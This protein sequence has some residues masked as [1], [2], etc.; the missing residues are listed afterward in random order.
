MRTVSLMVLAAMTYASAKAVSPGE[1]KGF[2]V[3][4]PAK[5]PLEFNWIPELKCWVGRHEVTQAQY[6]AV[7]GTNPSQF[8]ALSNPVDSVSWH[9]ATGFCAKLTSSLH[10]DRTLSADLEIRLPWEKEWTVFVGDAKL[11]DAVHQRWDARKG[12]L[13]P[14]PVGSLAA[15]NYALY[16]VRGNVFEWCLDW[17]DSQQKERVLRGGSWLNNIDYMAVEYRSHFPP[18]YRHNVSGFR[19]ILTQTSE[20]PH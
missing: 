4:L 17:F 9:D 8:K 14:L 10:E 1:G 6:E 7:M 11:T 3:E 12:F 18:D 5:V 13:G 19:V 15:N 20:H 2:K 16:D